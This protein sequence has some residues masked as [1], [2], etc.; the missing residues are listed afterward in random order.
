[1][2]RS[3]VAGVLPAHPEASYIDGRWVPVSSSGTFEVLDCSTEEVVTAVGAATVE[4]VDAAVIAARKA[5]D[6]GPWPLMSPTERAGYLRAI[7]AELTRRGDDFARLWSV[8]SGIVYSLQRPG[9]RCSCRAR[10]LP[11]PIWPSR[12]RSGSRTHPRPAVP[13]CSCANRSV[14]SRRSCPGTAP[15]A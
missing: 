12:S 11:M 3:A 1:M 6:S 14:S 15:P 13:V 8:E 4:D 7:A 10:S 2:T 5:F 9:F